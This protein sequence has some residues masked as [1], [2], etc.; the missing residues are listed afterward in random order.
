MC[1]RGTGGGFAGHVCLAMKG[2]VL[3]PNF[4]S[5]GSYPQPCMYTSRRNSAG[6]SALPNTMLLSTSARKSVLHG[7]DLIICDNPIIL[8]T[9]LILNASLVGY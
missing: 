5:L 4:D 8:S 6:K 7:D 2:E 3:S 1:S 9:E